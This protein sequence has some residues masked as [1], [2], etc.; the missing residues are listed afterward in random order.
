MLNLSE[1]PVG[2]DIQMY[3]V[4]IYLGPIKKLN[5]LTGI[6]N[7]LQHL[8]EINIDIKLIKYPHAI[9]QFCTVI[10]ASIMNRTALTL[11]LDIDGK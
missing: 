5:K 6:E 9:R 11:S 1:S 3:T 8:R 2:T 7:I 10:A 4:Q